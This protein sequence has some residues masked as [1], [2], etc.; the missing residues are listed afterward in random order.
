M[1]EKN[2]NKRKRGRVGLYF[3]K[4]SFKCG[5]I[6]LT[7]YILFLIFFFIP[8]LSFFVFIPLSFCVF[9]QFNLFRVMSLF[10]PKGRAN[11]AGESFI[12]K[13]E[14]K[15]SWWDKLYYCSDTLFFL[16]R[17]FSIDQP[18]PLFVYFCSFQHTNFTEQL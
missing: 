18:R 16:I 11:D 6:S 10:L 8:P 17:C 15:W 2:E 1:F 12:R 7:F 3:F 14:E 4:K 5:N 9:V 13:I